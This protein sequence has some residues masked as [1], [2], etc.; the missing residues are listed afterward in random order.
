MLM[1]V[2]DSTFPDPDNPNTLLTAYGWEYVCEIAATPEKAIINAGMLCSFPYILRQ[3][4]LTCAM[5][6]LFRLLW[7]GYVS[8]IS[9]VRP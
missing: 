6:R 9:L 4:R 5:S 1:S 8:S 2:V 3:M 7:I